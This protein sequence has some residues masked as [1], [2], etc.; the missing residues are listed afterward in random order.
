M[1]LL[2][3]S[4][5]GIAHS[6]RNRKIVNMKNDWTSCIEVLAQIDRAEQRVKF[7]TVKLRETFLAKWERTKDKSKASAKAFADD[8]EQAIESAGWGSCLVVSVADLPV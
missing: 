1:R 7:T 2:S 8:F 3:H 6:N 5:A 4:I